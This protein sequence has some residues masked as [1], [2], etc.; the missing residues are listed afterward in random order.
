MRLSLH[1]KKVSDLAV[2]PKYQTEGSAGFDIS[3]VEELT[4]APGQSRLIKT[5]LSV[6][7]PPG[8]E[9]QIRSRSG[10]AAKH[11]VS[12]LNSPGTI[13]SDYRSEVGVI[14]MNSSDVVFVVHVGDRIAQGVVAA[15]EQVSFYEVDELDETTRN[16][17]FGSTGVSGAAKEPQT[18]PQRFAEDTKN[19]IGQIMGN[20][21]TNKY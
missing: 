2:I 8:F 17:G 11:M 12:V 21:T 1:I 16:G 7:V 20:A 5:G 18:F 10:L 19:A 13:D 9:L 6:A 4:I 15:V 14:L 3:A